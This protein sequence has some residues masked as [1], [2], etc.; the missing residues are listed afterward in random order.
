MNPGDR[1]ELTAV[2]DDYIPFALAP[3]DLGSVEFTDSL[4]TIHIW[5]ENAGKRVGITVEDTALIR[6]TP[7]PRHRA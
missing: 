4:G 3:G 7:G 6:R 5:C 1:V 2:T